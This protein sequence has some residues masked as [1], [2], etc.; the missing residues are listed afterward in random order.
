MRLYKYQGSRNTPLV[1]IRLPWGPGKQSSKLIKS[2]DMK[3]L[4]LIFMLVPLAVTPQNEPNH[5]SSKALPKVDQSSK[6]SEQNDEEQQQKESSVKYSAKNLGDHAFRIDL[7]SN[8]DLLDGVRGSGLYA[9][10]VTFAPNLDTLFN[11]L[12]IGVLSGI[13]QYRSYDD[14]SAI[15]TS[16]FQSYERVRIPSDGDTAKFI[17]TEYNVQSQTSYDNTSFYLSPIF[18]LRN[19]SKYVLYLGLLYNLERRKVSTSIQVESTVLDT[20]ISISEPRRFLRVR[21]PSDTKSVLYEH[22]LGIHFPLLFRISD[23]VNVYLHPSF[24]R[25]W[26]IFTPKF[27]YGMRFNVIDLSSGINLGGEI[28]GYFNKKSSRPRSPL[29]NLF[30]SK[31]FNI[32]ALSKYDGTY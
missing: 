25:T 15:R 12:K 19:N 17:P 20:I 9:N 18:Q 21:P 7:G 10:I 32:D 14:S 29:I 16:S 4:I 22:H 3:Y 30:I 1:T 2:N 26:S 8:F 5:D 11:V 6:E 28:T 13:R 23:Q 27:F 24:G 31:A